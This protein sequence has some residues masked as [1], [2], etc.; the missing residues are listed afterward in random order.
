[1]IT[2]PIGIASL[3]G[4]KKLI[5]IGIVAIIVYGTMEAVHLVDKVEAHETKINQIESEKKE[6]LNTVTRMDKNITAI[7]VHLKVSED[8]SE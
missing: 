5:P 4:P 2:S 8:E 3:F 7:K 6:L 1:M